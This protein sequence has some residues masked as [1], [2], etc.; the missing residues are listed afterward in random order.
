VKERTYF[1]E[2]PASGTQTFLVT[3]KSK[4]EAIRKARECRTGEGVEPQ[5]GDLHTLHW[6]RAKVDL[7][8]KEPRQ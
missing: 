2:V 1:L 6:S 5:S 3:A 8:D 7:D 4:A